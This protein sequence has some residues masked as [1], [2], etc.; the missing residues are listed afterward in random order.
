M[1]ITIE[2]EQ[3]IELVSPLAD[4]TIRERAQ[5]RRVDAFGTLTKFMQRPKPEEIEITDSQKRYEPFWYGSA[6]ALYVY[7]RKHRYE[8]PVA[9]EVR[10]VTLYDTEHPVDKKAFHLEALEHCREEIK[11]EMMLE[12]QHGNERDYHKYLA[13][14][15]REVDNLEILRAGD[16]LVVMP[17]VRSSFL[18]GKLTQALMKTIQADKIHEQRI[19]IDKVI[20]Y[21]RPV[22]AFEFF[23]KPK[24]K[25][26]VV[27]FDAL[28]GELSNEPGQMKKQLTGVLENDDLF[29]IGSDVVGTFVP[30]ANIAIKLGRLAARK[31]LK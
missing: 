4:E 27:E 24:D 1:D 23:W 7:D 22:Y 12:P 8:V 31:A 10:S 17:E 16:T 9:D 2:R 20:L 15:G 3:I 13:F 18:V 6:Q 30:G 28:T 26:Q 19:D 14:T 25:H 5:A 29:D 11:R 21:L